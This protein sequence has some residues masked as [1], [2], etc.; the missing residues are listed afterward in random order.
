MLNK[1]TIKIEIILFLLIYFVLNRFE[2]QTKYHVAYTCVCSEMSWHNLFQFKKKNETNSIRYEM[3]CN[4]EQTM[5]TV[6]VGVFKLS[7]LQLVYAVN[8]KNLSNF[9][10]KCFYLY[11]LLHYTNRLLIKKW[12]LHLSTTQT[13]KK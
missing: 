10:L 13:I 8:N 5:S 6:F 2:I 12:I 4:H 3:Y 7:K 11:L 1:H 9:I